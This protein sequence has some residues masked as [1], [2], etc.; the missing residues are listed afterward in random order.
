MI[1]TRRPGFT[2]DLATLP[3]IITLSRICIVLIAAAAFFSGHPRLGIGLAV[4]GALT[5][6]LDGYIARR[7]GAVTLLGEILDQFSDI[8]FESLALYVALALYHFLPPWVMIAYLGREFW[9]TT[10]RRYMAAHQVN[11]PTSMVGKLKTNFV[12]WG[13]LPTFLSITGVFPALE[14]V[15]G[16]LG[17]LS[18]VVGLVFGYASAWGYT[19]HLVAEY[20]RVRAFRQQQQRT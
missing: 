7:T 15:L 3:N 5:D 12:M 18:I 16:H 19:R 2:A 10:I 4:V 8:F 6:Y 20:D 9:V 1:D 11:I 17:R 13:F 14:P